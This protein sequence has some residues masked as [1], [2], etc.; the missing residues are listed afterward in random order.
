MIPMKKVNLVLL[1]SLIAFC[2]Q[3]QDDLMDIL[4]E[5]EEKTTRYTIAT[6][7]S[8]RLIN[9]H[10]VE[11][12]T[13]NVLE[14]VIGHRFGRVNTGFDELFGLDNANI[15][16]GLEY[17]ITDE[18]NVGIGRSSF[19]KTFDGF[20]KYKVLK[21]SNVMPVTLTGFA[22]AIID[23]SDFP[24]ETADFDNSH[25]YSY[26]YQLLLARKFSPGL[27]FQ[28]MPTYVHRN[29]VLTE[30]DANDLI[31]LGVGGR[32]KLNARVAINAE[33]YPQITDSSDTFRNAIAIGFDIET[34][35]HVFQLHLTN[36]QQMN[37][38]GFIG[39]TT[40]DFFDG[41]IHFG[42]NISRVFNVGGGH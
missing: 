11:T 10:T 38:P 20:L 28:F 32:A 19:Q 14:F 40:G 25:R 5:T 36:A 37:E 34:G 7:K 12:R 31:A 2:I 24:S 6:F 41:D 30:E 18:L 35:G 23:T 29:L 33:W 13:A 9:G 26:T 39:E 4:N 3:A 15:R 22:S 1:F 21:Q 16:F 17:G 8:T 42:F 27:S